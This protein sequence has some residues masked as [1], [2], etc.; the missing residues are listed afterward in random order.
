MI[1][2]IKVSVPGCIGNLGSGFD[3]MGL[4][5]RCFNKFT[6]EPSDNLS[7]SVSTAGIERNQKNLC[8][9]SFKKACNFLGTSIPTIRIRIDANIPPGAGLGSSGTAVIA[10]TV[11]AFLFSGQ[12]IDIQKLFRI[13]KRMEG[14]L[15]NIAASFLGGLVVVAEQD[16]SIIWKRFNVPPEITIVFFIPEM[17]CSTKEAR[18]VLPKKILLKDAVFNLSR[19][20]LIPSSIMEKNKKLLPVALNDRL[21][22]PYRKNLYPVSY[23]HL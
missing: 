6:F 5:I 10:G 21:H 18:K 22:Q 15:D 4:S 12:K 19:V 3:C 1:K 17:S 13:A 20:S 16:E 7:I 2:K 8:F 23:T 14:H 9:Q 11:A